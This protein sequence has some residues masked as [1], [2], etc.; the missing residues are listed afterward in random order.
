MEDRTMEPHI[1]LPSRIPDGGA[2]LPA[3][4]EITLAAA[5]AEARQLDER[6]QWRLTVRAILPHL[7][8]RSH[9]TD[10]S[11]RVQL[12]SDK[13]AIAAYEAVARLMDQVA[14]RD[15]ET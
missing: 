10:P 12:A 2:E 5:E 7:Q 14:P 8:A 11:A 1:P 15:V 13:A 3:D 4:D 6:A 9:D